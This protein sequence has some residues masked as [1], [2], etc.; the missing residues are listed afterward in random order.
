MSAEASALPH[1]PLRI[2]FMGS[3]DFSVRMLDALLET[4]HEIICVYSQP[5]RRAGRGK[6]ERKT[7]VHQAAEA[8]GID[9]RTPRTLKKQAEQDAF[10]ALN[11]DLAIIVAYGLILP[12]PVLDAPRLGCVNLHAS[13]LPRW[14]GAAPIQRAIM[15]GDTVSGI[16]AMQMDAGLDTGHILHTETTPITPDDTAG[17]LHDRLA[18][19]GANLLPKVITSLANGTAA[20]VRQSEHGIIYASKLS[21]EDQKIDWTRSAKDVDAQIRGLSPFP[22]ARFDWT[23]TDANTPIRIKPLMSLYERGDG[24]PGEVLDDNLLVAC[25]EGAV[26]I[27]QLQR[28]GKGPMDAA[29]F[30]RGTKIHRGQIFQ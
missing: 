10:A 17:T 30:L 6:A 5:P 26:R 25:G 1:G 19:L 13:L 23:P 12:Q 4:E 15:A 11:A 28:P 29:N 16:Q 9:V 24:R 22:A 14:R 3:P 8:A 27:T 18:S 2:V 21:P 20:P 7:P